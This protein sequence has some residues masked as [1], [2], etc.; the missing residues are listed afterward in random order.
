MKRH[1]GGKGDSEKT[2]KQ[3]FL[4]QNFHPMCVCVF[5]SQWNSVRQM[6]N[7]HLLP[8]LVVV[9]FKDMHELLLYYTVFFF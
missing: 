5:V 9:F 2:G 6:S 7:R 1:K 4:L 8:S 3:F